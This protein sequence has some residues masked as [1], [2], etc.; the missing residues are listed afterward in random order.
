MR[1]KNKIK[2]TVCVCLTRMRACT[3]FIWVIWI[4]NTHMYF[5]KISTSSHPLVWLLAWLCI[6]VSCKLSDVWLSYSQIRLQSGRWAVHGVFLQYTVWW[7]HL[8]HSVFHCIFV[9]QQGARCARCTSEVL[10]C[11]QISRELCKAKLGNYLHLHRSRNTHRWHFKVFIFRL[12]LGQA[13]HFWVICI[14][15]RGAV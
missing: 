5:A 8:H 12:G 2:E 9:L 15:S 6:S 4:L 14:T 7:H 3:Y 10:Y 1:S 11:L 13:A